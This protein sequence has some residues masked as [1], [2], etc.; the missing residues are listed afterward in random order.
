MELQFFKK[1]NLYTLNP[2]KYIYYKTNPRISITV[3]DAISLK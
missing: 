2:Q 1:I 3:I